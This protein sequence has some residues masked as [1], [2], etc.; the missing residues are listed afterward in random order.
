MR[1]VST[2]SLLVAT[3]YNGGEETRQRE[4]VLDQVESNGQAQDDQREVNNGQTNDSRSKLHRPLCQGDAY[5]LKGRSKS[6]EEGNLGVGES[7]WRKS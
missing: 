7:N 2:D 3:Y 5:Q 1:R 4:G 6:V